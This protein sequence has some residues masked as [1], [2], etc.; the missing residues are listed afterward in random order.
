MS[1]PILWQEAFVWFA[2]QNTGL[3]IFILGRLT[4]GI[5]YTVLAQTGPRNFCKNDSISTSGRDGVQIHL[6]LRN[7]TMTF[8]TRKRF[9]FAST[10]TFRSWVQKC[11]CKCRMDGPSRLLFESREKKRAPARF[12][13]HYRYCMVGL[14]YSGI[15]LLPSSVSIHCVIESSMSRNLISGRA[16]TFSTIGVAAAAQY[17]TTLL[18]DP[19]LN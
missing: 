5:I 19:R 4:S 2:T 15:H 6:W 12:M 14:P 7:F 10:L 3:Q 13:P 16:L 17:C 8:S 18:I 9:W 1:L 11:F